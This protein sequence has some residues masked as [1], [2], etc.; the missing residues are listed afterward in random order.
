M[1]I[2]CGVFRGPCVARQR[3]KGSAMRPQK[4][5]GD[6]CFCAELKGSSLVRARNCEGET[7]EAKQAAEDVLAQLGYV[8]VP[9]TIDNDEWQFNADYIGALAAG[10]AAAATDI[11][12]EYIAHMQERTRHYRN[13]AQDALGRD[14]K[15]ILLLHC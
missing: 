12:A 9:V 4:D 14:V 2:C 7:A 6:R 10:D 15:H 3:L 8:N 11:A 1:P 13:L 5:R